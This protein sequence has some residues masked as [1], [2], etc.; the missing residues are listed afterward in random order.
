MTAQLLLRLGSADASSN[1]SH[2]ASQKYICQKF[3]SDMCEGES[4]RRI[5][6]K[7]ADR[8]RTFL[9]CAV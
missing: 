8:A 2:C 7:F 4:F 9:A 1:A 6:H 3:W 5:S